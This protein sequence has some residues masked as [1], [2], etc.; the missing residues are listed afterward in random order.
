MNKK[1]KILV[2]LNPAARG[3]RAK[4]LREKIA[5]LS[6]HVVVRS[7]ARPATLEVS[8]PAR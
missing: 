5:S 7:T 3:E 2:I 1:H 6:H 8:P 4:A